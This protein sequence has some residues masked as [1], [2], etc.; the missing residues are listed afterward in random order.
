MISD[1]T[2]KFVTDKAAIVAKA[3]GG[4]ASAVDKATFGTL[5]VKYTLMSV[6]A[7][8]RPYV[9]AGY[10]YG[11]IAKTT[12]VTVGGASLSESA[13]LSTY[14]VQLGSDLAGQMNKSGLGV[15]LGV[16]RAFGERLGVDA[17]YRL[18]RFMAKTSVIDGDQAL[19]AQRLQVGVLYRF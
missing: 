19:N 5:G 2:P 14:G 11:R 17:S 1:V 3:L 12:T 13:L 6:D 15:V 16:T 7:A 10:T 4:S 8:F 18:N 9:G